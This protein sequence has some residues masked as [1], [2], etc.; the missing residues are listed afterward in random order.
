MKHEFLQRLSTLITSC[1][2][3]YLNDIRGDNSNAFTRKR[4]IT[5]LMLTCQMLNQKGRTQ[6]YEIK[7]IMDNLGINEEISDVGFYKARMKYDPNALRLMH[8]DFLIQEYDSRKN[9]LQTY[10][11]YFVLAIDGSDVILPSDIKSEKIS[12]A[13]YK[14]NAEVENMPVQCKISA[15]C[16]VLN[17]LVLAIEIDE[18]KHDERDHAISLIKRI[19]KEY[20]EKVIIIFD[21]GYFS[22]IL[23]D[24]LDELKIK[25]VMRLSHS[26][27]KI[28]QAKVEKNKVE[29]MDIK[30]T[31]ASSNNFRDQPELREKIMS[32]TYS[33]RIAHID[34]E[35]IKEYLLTNLDSDEANIDS[36]KH[37]YHLRWGIE[38]GYRDFKSNLKL[39][40]F[41]G[42]KERLVIQD[43]Y[44]TMWFYNILSFF[45]MD[46]K[47]DKQKKYK[48]D[49]TINRNAA[50]GT[51]KN[52]FIIALFHPNE[53]I[54]AKYIDIIDK[55]LS[56][57]LVPSRPNRKYSREHKP[58]NHSKMSYRSNY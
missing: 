6:R 24:L 50:I 22:Y 15:L 40:E 30:V 8:R 19:P 9:Q 28:Y 39:E 45:L 47:I 27:L 34:A 35:T 32:K 38:T 37:L 21:R 1:H 23:M 25:Y 58:K 13:R 42:K 41:S 14:G 18:Y 4:K 16:D 54:R 3:K 10:K 49:M 46:E 53:S 29:H 12:A 57:Y 26:A 11:N 5:P 17:K 52:S 56:K 43:I 51:L 55:N 2:V 33:L 44:A 7:N 48:Y 31:K 20:L 36:L